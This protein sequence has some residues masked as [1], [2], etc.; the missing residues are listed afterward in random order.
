V[1]PRANERRTRA[2]GHRVDLAHARQNRNI[3]PALARHAPM[4]ACSKQTKKTHHKTRMLNLARPL[5]S[6]HPKQKPKKRGPRRDAWSR[7]KRRRKLTYHRRRNR[8]IYVNRTT[9]GLPVA[10]GRERVAGEAGAPPPCA[11]LA[12][13]PPASRARLASGHP[14]VLIGSGTP[15]PPLAKPKSQVTRIPHAA[16]DT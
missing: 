12:S 14:S 3:R 5:P 9:D 15:S 6:I 10:S 1:R 7:F 8:S 11:L 2:H 13:S 16:C 4:R